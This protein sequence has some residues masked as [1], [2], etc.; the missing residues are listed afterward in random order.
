MA[1]IQHL[2]IHSQYSD[3]TK[4]VIADYNGSLVTL[5][6]SRDAIQTERDAIIAD[7]LSGTGT[8]ASLRK[9]CDGARDKALQADIAELG[10]IGSL[11]QI[12]AAARADWQAEAVR[13]ES[14]EAARRL[15]LETAADTLKMA[16]P[17]PA[18]HSLI[19]TDP[20]RLT[21][22]RAAGLARSKARETI[23]RPGDLARLEEIKA[24]IIQALTV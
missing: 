7:A 2:P 20:A 1:K 5:G 3:T 18:R 16:D 10:L 24:S 15:E 22:E 13:Q 6:L 19:L 17:C 23:I 21:A 8:A 12:E 4:Q 9:R 11:E 14:V